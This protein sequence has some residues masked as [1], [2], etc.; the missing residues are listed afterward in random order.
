MS[1]HKKA[2]RQAR[3]RNNHLAKIGRPGMPKK[4]SG[5]KASRKQTLM[6]QRLNER[7]Q[8]GARN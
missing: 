6:L 5:E 2:R 1:I 7:K 4:V 3:N 8:R